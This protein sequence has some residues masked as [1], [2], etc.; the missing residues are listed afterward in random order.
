MHHAHDDSMPVIAG[1]FSLVC[2]VQ[3]QTPVGNETS[4]A[5]AVRHISASGRILW[6]A[7]YRHIHYNGTQKLDSIMAPK[8]RTES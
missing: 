5:D 1:F 8:N 7:G 6:N 4:L 3:A 2:A